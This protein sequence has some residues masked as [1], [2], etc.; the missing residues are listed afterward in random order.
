[1]C[2]KSID[3]QRIV[4]CGNNGDDL[5]SLNLIVVPLVDILSISGD[6]AIDGGCPASDAWYVATA[7]HVD[8]TLW[9][10]H[11]HSDDLYAVASRHVAVSLL[12]DQ[13]PL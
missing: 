3:Q 2:A 4:C 6:L 13:P 8:A 12:S 1:M 7:K 11:R 10:S 5:L 9:L